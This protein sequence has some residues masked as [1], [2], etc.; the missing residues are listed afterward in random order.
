[1]KELQLKPPQNNCGKCRIV[2][3]EE[4]RML[5]KLFWLF[6]LACGIVF[7]YKEARHMNN[8]LQVLYDRFY[9]PLPMT[10]DR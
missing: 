3:E 6:L 10:E 2:V 5:I 7:C 1:M 4:L 9:T 8:I